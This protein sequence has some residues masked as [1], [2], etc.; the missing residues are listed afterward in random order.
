[1]LKTVQKW[2]LVQL[3]APDELPRADREKTFFRKG[4][5]GEPK[6]AERRFFAQNRRYGHRNAVAGCLLTRA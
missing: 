5:P 6:G 3:V 4:N 1:M 2:V